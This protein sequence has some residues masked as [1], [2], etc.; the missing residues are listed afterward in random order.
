[1]IELSK[2][3]IE[4]TLK[5]GAGCIMDEMNFLLVQSSDQTLQV[6]QSGA[7]HTSTGRYV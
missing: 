4:F 6:I 3:I 1:M 7:M 2:V 5:K